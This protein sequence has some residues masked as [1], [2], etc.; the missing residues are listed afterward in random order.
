MANSTSRPQI[1]IIDDE[2]Q[3]QKFLAIALKAQG[4]HVLQADC[5]EQGLQRLVL[6]G[7][8]LV[9]LDLGLP[10]QDGRDVLAE[11]RSWSQL[12]V[13]VLSVRADESEKVALLDAGAND[14]VTKPFSIQELLARIR[15]LLR[16]QPQQREAAIFDDGQ[17]KID[18]AQHQVYLHGQVL[19]LSRKEYQLLALLAQHSGQL[20]TQ[21]H[22]LNAL[23][24]PS[25]QQDTHYLRILLAKIRHKL[26]DDPVH[27][28][29]IATEP[30]VGLRFL[31]KSMLP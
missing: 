31:A 9:I 21:P 14:Y 15:V 28:R 27:P 17:L 20:L 1:L 24:G 10:D 2:L 5:A 25:H 23:W 4:Y 12:P 7:A 19:T 30:G 13:L 29:Y 26:A 3:V 22:I 6:Q 18:F 8:D 16:Q 11:I